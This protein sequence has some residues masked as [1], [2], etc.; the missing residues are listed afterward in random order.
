M[1]SKKIIENTTN[2]ITGRNHGQSSNRDHHQDGLGQD[3]IIENQSETR[4]MHKIVFTYRLTLSGQYEP[5]LIS[6]H[7]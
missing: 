7:F 6:R 4:S 1:Q 3:Q 2:Q 5:R